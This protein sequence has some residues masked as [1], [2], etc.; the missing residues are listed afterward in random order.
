MGHI[1]EFKEYTYYIEYTLSGVVYNKVWRF[2]SLEDLNEFDNLVKSKC[3]IN[4]R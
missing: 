3:R 2:K 4:K 1:E